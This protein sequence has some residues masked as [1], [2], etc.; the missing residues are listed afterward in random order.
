MI[1]SIYSLSC[2]KYWTCNH[3][4]ELLKQIQDKRMTSRL[5]VWPERLRS[6]CQSLAL[7]VL[8]PECWW[9]RDLSQRQYGLISTAETVSSPR[10]SE[11]TSQRSGIFMILN[12]AK[13]ALSVC[14]AASRHSWRDL[15]AVFTTADILLKD[16]A[17]ALDEVDQRL[18]K[19]GGG[20]GFTQVQFKKKHL[21]SATLSPQSI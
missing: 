16:L 3:G 1:Q 17:E 13:T 12:I 2:R 6:W 8:E 21:H 19:E 18:I 14:S 15:G 7:L 5:R 10:E 11:R 9:K 20:G 4:S